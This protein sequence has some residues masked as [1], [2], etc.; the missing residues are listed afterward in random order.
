MTRQKLWTR[1]FAII[2]LE[3]FLVALNFYLLMIVVAKFATDRF[4]VSTAVAGLAAGIFIAGG[5]VARPLSGKWIRRVGQTRMLYAGALLGLALTLLYFAATTPAL[6]LL[7]RFLHGVAFGITTVAT[8]TIVAGVVPRERY[9][10]G[11]GYF[12]TGATVA[13]GIGP[14][15]GLLLIQHGSFNAII[16]TCSIVSAIA[17]L[18]I[19]LLS[20]S[21]LELTKEQVEEARGFRLST[22][23]EARVVPISLV[24]FVS[25][26]CYSSIVS[27]LALYAEEIHL[28]AAAGFFFVVYAV[29]VFISRP[30]VGRRFDARGENSVMYAALFI[31]ALGLALFSQA[32]GA[33]VLLLA[34]AAIGF[35][36]GAVQSSGQ[37]IV[38]KLTPPHRMGLAI[39]TRFMF[40]D[41]GTGIGP[42]LWGLLIP[43]TGYRGMY[44]VVA[45]V[46]AGCLLLYYAL[47]GKRV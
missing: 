19:P 37:A 26:M 7:I 9:G 41:M 38:I 25:Y 33:W 18:I 23:I 28:V 12:A 5:L 46:A 24:L 15:I 20:V 43:I 44:A 3:N 2:T 14:L 47:Y 21:E 10:E 8:G 34:A 17:L 11:I 39:S 22:Y 29:V 6:L 13:V 40:I 36:F 16:L 30:F 35:G 42:L 31:F 27:F 45:T 1:S 32:R 4:G